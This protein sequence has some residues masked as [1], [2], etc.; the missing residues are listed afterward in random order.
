MRFWKACVL[1]YFGG[2]AYMFLE[3]L[4]RG[5]S[6]G[7]MFLLGGVCF[8]VIGK[9][10]RAMEKVP[11]ALQLI[12]FSGVITLLELFTGL[13]VNGNYRVW[14]YRQV[15]YNFLGQI[16]LPFSLLWIPVSLAARQL[17]R[18]AD[19]GLASRSFAKD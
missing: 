14:D 12:L 11:L 19:K 10:S 3:F 7:S 9:L 6:H 13:A 8:V 17:F 1:F 18:L 2:S 16:C 5:R 15:P 4:W